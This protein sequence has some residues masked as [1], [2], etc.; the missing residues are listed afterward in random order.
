MSRKP[1]TGLVRVNIDGLML[2]RYSKGEGDSPPVYEIGFVR[3]EG[4]DFTICCKVV[5]K[6][7]R[8]IEEFKVTPPEEGVWSLEIHRRAPDVELFIDENVKFDR[9]SLSEQCLSGKISEE[10]PIRMDFRW[11]LDL[12]GAEFPEHPTTLDLK[13]NTLRPIIQFPHGIVY[14]EALGDIKVARSFKKNNPDEKINPEPFGVVSDI[15]G[16]DIDAKPDDLLVLRNV[17]TGEGIFRF[18]IEEGRE[19]RININNIP[20]DRG[21][22]HLVSHFHFYYSVFSNVPYEYDIEP[23]GI[24]AAARRHDHGADAHAHDADAH[25]HG[26][27]AHAHNE[28]GANE[29]PPVPPP[30][31]VVVCGGGRGGGGAPLCGGTH[32]SNH[33][34]NNFG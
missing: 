16:I 12:E 11:I 18:R 8:T 25:A 10:D 15:I 6:N 28:P 14:N 5:D 20:P 30:T 21:L 23:V 22:R 7:N 13:P 9:V 27:D 4:H 24:P 19:V 32:L 17:K 3:A 2:G 26:A 34:T 33:S 29:A 31:D 1:R